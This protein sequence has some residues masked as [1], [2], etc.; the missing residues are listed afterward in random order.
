[1]LLKTS[2]YYVKSDVLKSLQSLNLD[3]LAIFDSKKNLR[4]IYNGFEYQEIYLYNKLDYYQ[5][6]YDDDFPVNPEIY[7]RM[8]DYEATAYDIIYRWRR[9]LL[10]SSDYKNVKSAYMILL[11]FWYSYL[12]K[13][14]IDIVYLNDAPHVPLLFILYSV[15]KVLGIRIIVSVNLLHLTPNKVLRYNTLNILDYNLLAKNNLSTSNIKISNHNDIYKILESNFLNKN[16]MITK[17]IIYDSSKSLILKLRDIIER[18]RIYLSQGR[19]LT[20]I[21]KIIYYSIVN[22]KSKKLL[23]F[24]SK[25]AEEPD[26]TKKYI[27]FPLHLQ[28]EAT[29]LPMGGKLID[30]LLIIDFIRKY[31]PKGVLLYVKEHPAYWMMNNR[32]ESVK[33][34]RNKNFYS[35]IAKFS[36][37]K[38]I[39]HNFDSLDLLDNSLGVVTINGSIAMEAAFK[40]KRVLMFGK[41]I[42][43]TL[44]NVL[45][46][47][48]SDDLIKGIDLILNNPLNHETHKRNLKSFFW[49]YSSYLYSIDIIDEKSDYG[50][51]HRH[52]ETELS[53]M[54]KF[55]EETILTKN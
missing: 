5:L 2:D 40:F 45:H 21:H 34:S 46:V 10:N 20:L 50:Q 23:N 51:I 19:I 44:P 41:V 9:S 13:N 12:I 53:A 28:P 35:T 31:L 32:Y 7:D 39:K 38:L 37:V 30:Q 42:Y 49:N 11:K 27:F 16:Y 4:S 47:K 15:C 54:I 48:N 24:A 55:Y 43:N 1:M 22:L 33:E 17:T 25:R 8:S 29:T 6:Q 18:G 14:K 26:L 52:I 36:N 3:F